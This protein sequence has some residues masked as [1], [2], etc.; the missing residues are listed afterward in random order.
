MSV[1]CFRGFEDLSSILC[2]TFPH[3]NRILLMAPQV[4]IYTR[5]CSEKQHEGRI[6]SHVNQIHNTPKLVS[7]HH[8]IHSREMSAKNFQFAFTVISI[9]IHSTVNVARVSWMMSWWRKWL[10][11]VIVVMTESKI[12]VWHKISSIHHSLFRQ[13][14]HWSVSSSRSKFIVSQH[15][16]THNVDSRTIRRNFEKKRKWKIFT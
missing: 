1:L 16:T 15:H 5:I 14:C 11:F 7:H 4:V 9:R 2:L 12:F 10:I 6:S 3:C 8:I 13:I